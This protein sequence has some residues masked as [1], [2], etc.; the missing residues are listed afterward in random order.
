MLHLK[1]IP[2]RYPSLKT[3]I[4]R[5]SHFLEYIDSKFSQHFIP[6]QCILVDEA[7]VQFKGKIGIITYNPIKPTTWGIRIYVLTD[8]KSGYV[9]SILPYYGSITTENLPNPELPI[10]TRI[11]LYLYKKLLE[12]IP[13]A[14]GYHMF[15]DRYYTSFL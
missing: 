12:K 4:Q 1:K 3:R 14:E 13:S 7:V 15:T 9:Y 11:P 10:T 8:S 2:P 5:A 6:E